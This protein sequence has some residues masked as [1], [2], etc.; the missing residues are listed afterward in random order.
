MGVEV[1]FKSEAGSGAALTVIAPAPGGPA[2][3]AGIRPGDEILAIDGQQT[4]TI[5]LYAAG[6]RGQRGRWTAGCGSEGG[7]R[8]CGCAGPSKG[9]EALGVLRERVCH[10]VAA[11]GLVNPALPPRLST[12]VVLPSPPPT[13]NLLQGP[14]GSQVVLSVKPG[15]GGAARDVPITRQPIQFNP[16]DTA[17]CSS[18]GKS[19]SL[20]G[21]GWR[22]VIR[23]AGRGRHMAGPRAVAGSLLPSPRP[24]PASAGQPAPG[25]SDAKL[26]QTPLHSHLVP[27]RSASQGLRPAPLMPARAA[28]TAQA[29]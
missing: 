3:R 17:L 29:R 16:V 18:S 13:G 15:A 24:L 20:G 8:C 7:R 28:F 9:L 4:S 5:S 27:R 26:S 12:R 2:E 6:K 1:G 14:E 22:G 10:Y 21:G 19:A 25:S 23:R 11:C